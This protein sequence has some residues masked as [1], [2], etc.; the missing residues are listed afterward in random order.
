MSSTAL[1]FTLS[2]VSIQ[3]IGQSGDGPFGFDIATD[4]N[5]YS[6]CTASD[7]PG[8]YRCSTA[9]KPH[10]DMEYYMVQAFPSTGICWI[11]GVGK[12]I[13][14]SGA[15]LRTKGAADRISAQIES[16]YGSERK[17]TDFLQYESIW[18]EFDDWMM[19]LVRNERYYMYVWQSETGFNPLKNVEQIYV[20][21]NA[22]SGNVGYVVV[23]FYGINNDDCDDLANKAGA[24]A[25]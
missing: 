15:G 22:L 12:D 3:S 7:S 14:D 10:P 6:S 9:S 18:D 20:A 23:E 2:F 13:D 21:A 11:K 5:N 16:V 19:G 25:F 4:I 24:E 1:F 8:M 17:L